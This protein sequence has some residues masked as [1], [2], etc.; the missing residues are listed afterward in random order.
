M[1][2]IAPLCSVSI[3]GLFEIGEDLGCVIVVPAKV[4][5]A[6]A[7]DCGTGDD[8][9]PEFAVYVGGPIGAGPIV[10]YNSE[11]NGIDVV[12]LSIPAEDRTARV[13]RSPCQGI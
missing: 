5:S 6:D 7:R 3:S 10:G 12:T 1:P 2:S 9:N 8:A 13:R 11:G 4:R